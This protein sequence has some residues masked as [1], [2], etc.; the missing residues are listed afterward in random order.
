M[1]L[2][3]NVIALGSVFEP[4]QWG[5]K[6]VGGDS[7]SIPNSLSPHV[8]LHSEFLP[9]LPAPAWLGLLVVRGVRQ[10]SP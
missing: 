10:G 8:P 9:C 1:D 5:P 2:Q 4:P 7:L 6:K 3:T